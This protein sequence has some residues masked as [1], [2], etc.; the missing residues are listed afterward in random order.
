GSSL[1]PPI[2][3]A[4]ILG[5]P[6]LY[7][8][9]GPEGG[10]LKKSVDFVVPYATGEKTHKEWV[11]SRVRLD[12]ERAAAGLEKYRPGRLYEPKSAHELM[13][14]ASF[15]DSG[16]IPLALSLDDSDAE[17]YPGWRMLVHDAVARAAGS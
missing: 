6:E 16:L 7:T 1:K 5:E 4:M 9:E 2:E 12:Q 14:Y 17:R 11:D 8:W 13:E 10:S 3:L 15:F